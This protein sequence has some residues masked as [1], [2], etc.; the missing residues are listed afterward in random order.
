M[1]WDEEEDN[2]RTLCPQHNCKRFA[3]PPQP[4]QKRRPGE[5]RCPGK[6]GSKERDSRAER[7]RD[8]ETEEASWM[9]GWMREWGEW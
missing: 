4:I 3:Y 7:R 6:C 1:W 2:R 8:E 9:D 5:L